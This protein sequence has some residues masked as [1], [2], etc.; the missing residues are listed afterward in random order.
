[1]KL[2][3]EL[4]VARGCSINTIVELH[5]LYKRMTELH[6][7]NLLDI[8]SIPE[9]NQEVRD[10]EF[11]MQELLKFEKNSAKHRHYLSDPKCKCPKEDGRELWGTDLR[12]V[13]ASC[14]L[15]TGGTV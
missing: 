2:N 4:A 5:S 3:E 10:I 12:I 6:D 1:M 8:E 7:I 9:Y 14:P 13:A 11:A 15:H